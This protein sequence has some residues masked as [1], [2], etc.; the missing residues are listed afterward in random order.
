[1]TKNRK[2]VYTII[3]REGKDNFWLKIGVAFVNEDG[4]LN[5]ILN[6]LPLNGELHVRD[7]KPQDQE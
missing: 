4:S 6:A 7:P 2:D 3:K 1:M 5:I